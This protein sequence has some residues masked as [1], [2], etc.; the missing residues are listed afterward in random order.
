[1]TLKSV[2]LALRGRVAFVIGAM[3][4]CS[5]FLDFW[6]KAISNLGPIRPFYGSS[7]PDPFVAVMGVGLMTLG[8]SYVRRERWD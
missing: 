1:M 7:A 8:W 4:F 6:A 5:G 3:M 2:I